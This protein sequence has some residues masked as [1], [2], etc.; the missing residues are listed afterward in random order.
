M[1]DDPVHNNNDR[2]LSQYPDDRVNENDHFQ[3]SGDFK[4]T[5]RERRSTDHSG[6]RL[7]SA[8]DG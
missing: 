5:E 3:R 7:K 1:I 2:I 4:D 8:E 6:A